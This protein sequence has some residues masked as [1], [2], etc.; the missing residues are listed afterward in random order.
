MFHTGNGS[1]KKSFNCLETLMEFLLDSG[2]SNIN[3]SMT[4]KNWKSISFWLM[5]FH[6]LPILWLNTIQKTLSY[7]FYYIWQMIEMTL[8][9][10][11]FQRSLE[12]KQEEIWENKWHVSDTKIIQTTGK[13]GYFTFIMC[14]TIKLSG[15]SSSLGDFNV[16]HIPLV[17]PYLL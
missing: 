10:T 15:F 5:T 13:S 7:F 14:Y 16:Q 9:I 6:I 8:K 17:F 11:R 3:T 2:I 4:K 1:K 12:T